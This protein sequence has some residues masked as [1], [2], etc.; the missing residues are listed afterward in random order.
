V[1]DIFLSYSRDDQ[2]TAR[3]FAEGFERAGLSVWWDQT[4]S[5]GE[6]Y[7][8]VTEKALEAARAVVVLWSKKSVGSRWVRA[9]ATQADRNGTLV[10][11]M[12]E[13][14]KR[15]IMFELKQSTDLSGWTGDP[16]DKTWQAYLA[17]VQRFVQKDAAPVAAPVLPVPDVPRRGKGSGIAIAAAVL[18]VVAAGAWTLM[19]FRGE[20]AAQGS[21]GKADQPPAATAPT[22]PAEVTLAVLPFANL[23]SDPEQEYFSD[24]LTEEIL[25]QLAQI[26]SLR[27]TGR[28]SSFSF[29]GKNEDLRVIGEK[30]GVANLLEGSIRKDGKTLRITAQLINA[31]DG[32]HL[33]SKTYDREPRNVFAIQ[34][35]IAKDVAGALSIKLDVGEMNRA[36]GGTTNLAAYEKYLRARTLRRQFL[37]P[38]AAALYREAVA[39]DPMFWRAWFGLHGALNGRSLT[40]L[41]SKQIL[42]NKE[43]QQVQQHLIDAAPDS[44]LKQAMLS[45]Y[46]F[47]QRR[48]ADSE[49]ALQAA[50]AAMPASEVETRLIACIR[51]L[52]AGQIVDAM[53][54]CERTARIDPLTVAPSTMFSG[55]LT[56]SGRFAEAQTE[57]TRGRALSGATQGLDFLALQRLL[58]GDAP[59]A[60]TIRNHVRS[61]PSSFPGNLWKTL[62]DNLETAQVER[63]AAIQ[64]IIRNPAFQDETSL[65]WIAEFA[66]FYGDRDSALKALQLHVAQSG[67]TPFVWMPRLAALR[68]DPRFKELL[69]ST[70]LVDYYRATGIWGDFCKPAG[71]DDFEC[72]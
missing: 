50:I 2:A 3:R 52:N 34:D 70:G 16:N 67:I 4:L 22:A 64:A 59:D 1:S 9:E 58:A 10:P 44:H 14:C 40:T 63:T 56:I 6:D 30:L 5:A 42:E 71:K 65:G 28:T 39:L 46:F 13:P 51:R 60:G 8:E 35:E 19:H 27:V 23:S 49:M 33:W 68:T 41:S 54:L 26:D 55:A 25:N 18:L 69:K 17:S 47:E 24:G 36:Q 31:R 32:S 53:G 20:P 7:D 57:Y 66:E 11:A 61:N 72:H 48:W 29:K 15:P 62:I 12:I 45:G 43:L 37:N 38:E 21:A